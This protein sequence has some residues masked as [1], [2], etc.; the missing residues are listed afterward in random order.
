MGRRRLL[1][2][3]S[4]QRMIENAYRPHQSFRFPFRPRNAQR[5]KMASQAPA[6]APEGRMQFSSYQT[7]GF[8]DEMFQADGSA[9]PHFELV[10]EIVQS[11]SDGKLLRYKHAAR[12]EE[13]TSELQSLRHLVFR[14]LLE[15]KR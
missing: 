3:S 1:F 2:P 12:S 9:R 5:Y 15:K 8:Y 11:L 4:H 13:H 6:R 10:Q 7:D 14:L